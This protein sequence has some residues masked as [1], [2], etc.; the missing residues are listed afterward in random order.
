MRDP[1]AK[2]KRHSIDRIELRCRGHNHYAALQEYGA[3]YM[4]RFAR[5]DNCTRVQLDVEGRE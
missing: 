4:A 5:R 2:A 3:A 1:W